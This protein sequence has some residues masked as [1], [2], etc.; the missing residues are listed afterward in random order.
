[1]LAAASEPVPILEYHVI[2]NPPASAPYPA[3]YVRTNAFAEQM[4]WLA[5]HHFH[6]VTLDRVLAAWTRG[7]PLPRRPVAITFDDGYRSVYTNALPIM[8]RYGW[9][10][11]VNL[12]VRRTEFAAGL[13]PPRVKSLIAARWE[14]DAHTMTHAD[15]TTLSDARLRYE[16]AGS[17][18]WLRRHFH[19]PVHFFCYPSGR[20]NARA[21][22]AVRAARYLGAETENP[23][24]ATLRE[25]WVLP[26]I[27]VNLDETLSEFARNVKAQR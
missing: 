7:K 15:V 24:F 12:L 11:N 25:R 27:R 21:I 1:M 16:V 8:R 17:R 2:A 6:P 20:Y 14:I 23:G 19:V 4:R 26:R 5:R 13:P 18:R 22:A 9:P 10:A 3:L